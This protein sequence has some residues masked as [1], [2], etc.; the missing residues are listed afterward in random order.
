M[1][2][3][4]NLLWAIVGGGFITA[5]EYLLVGVVC[6]VTIVGIPFGMQCFKIA[7][8]A[9]FP[10]GKD[11]QSRGGVVSFPL[12]VLWFIFAGLWIFLSHVALALP[13]AVSIIGIPFAYQHLKL[14]M[15]ALTPFGA[16][17]TAH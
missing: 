14:G 4:L 3:L 10:F 5:I 12:N 6:C 7:G 17:I 1:N 15:L 2:L 13:L 8:L 9:L 11:F 16:R